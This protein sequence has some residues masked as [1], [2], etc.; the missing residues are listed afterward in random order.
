MGMKEFLISALG[1]ALELGIGT[2]DDVLKHITPDVLSVHLPRPLWARLITACLGAPKVNSQLVVDTVGIPNLCEHMPHTLLWNVLADIGLRA[3]G[4][5]GASSIPIPVIGASTA[6]A[7]SASGSIASAARVTP[8]SGI[9]VIAPIGKSSPTPQSASNGSAPTTAPAATPTPT[10]TPAIAPSAPADAPRSRS[11]SRQPFG[12]QAGGAGAASRSGALAPS[13]APAAAAAT[14]RR[15][16]AAAPSPADRTPAPT[17]VTPQ[18]ASALVGSRVTPP[19][20]RRGTTATD[21]D[22]DT[23][24]RA[25]AWKSKDVEVDDDQL[26]DWSSSEET[27]TTGD[28]FGDRKPRG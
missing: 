23:D 11:P 27:V 9:P 22:I 24:V 25:E 6:S 12:R 7:S 15:P 13:Q 16:Q 28:G 21:F 5:T 3:L 10:P 18:P 4:K 20:P 8:A 19:S 2:T 1:S 26:I 17:P 14:A